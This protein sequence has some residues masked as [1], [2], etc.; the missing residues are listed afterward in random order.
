MQ[1]INSGADTYEVLCL[2]PVTP[3]TPRTQR[4]VRPLGSRNLVESGAQSHKLGRMGKIKGIVYAL[5]RRARLGVLRGFYFVHRGHCPLIQSD[6][7]GLVKK[8][9]TNA[10]V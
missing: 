6:R 2:A 9:K 10:T 8:W 4:A 3:L 7:G 5:I 1:T